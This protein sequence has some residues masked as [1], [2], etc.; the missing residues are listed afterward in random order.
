MVEGGNWIK[1][2]EVAEP[3]KESLTA[4]VLFA[5]ATAEEVAGVTNGYN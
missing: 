4:L 2:K 1:P 5:A 3:N